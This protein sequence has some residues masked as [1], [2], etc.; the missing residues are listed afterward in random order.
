MREDVTGRMND[1]ENFERHRAHLQAVAFRILGSRAEADDALQEAWIRFNR[2]DLSEVAN[3]P[4]WLTTVVSR[5]CLTM[6]DSRKRRRE[7]V[8]DHNDGLPDM[9][10]TRVDE[11]APDPVRE[12]LTADAV[13][14]ALTVVLETLS[15][16][17]RIAFV[18]HDIFGL[19]FEDVAGVLDRS[20][21]AARQLA[22]RARR[23]VRGTDPDTASA[24]RAV[25]D[26][27]LAAARGGDF[28]DLLALLDPDIVLRADFGTGVLQ[29]ISGAREVAGGARS[30]ATTLP[31]PEPIV[32][33]GLPAVLVREDGQPSR[34][35]RF[36]VEH[37]RVTAIDAIVGPERVGRL[38]PWALRR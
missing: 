23:R 1:V 35:L 4:G 6:L 19:P 5:V 9:V 37:G 11:T 36:T 30:A 13:G 17:E 3:V 32:A 2:A 14:G 28:E 27:F 24:D 7:D 25:V 16:P 22:S 29:T 18:L 21:A 20:P 26:A 31:L 15:P 34:I 38:V 8:L 10:V 33:D 12:A